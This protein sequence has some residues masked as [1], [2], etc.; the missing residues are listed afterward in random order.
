M[1]TI[2][3]LIAHGSRLAEAASAHRA[4]CARLQQ[5]LGGIDIEPGFLELTDPDIPAAI[6]SAVADGAERVVVLPYFLHPGNHTLRDIPAAVEAARNRHPQI[7]I[8]QAAMFG[9][10]PAIIGALAEQVRTSLGSD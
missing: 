8:D 3:V 7:T 4:V 10:D 1:H 5:E 2:V 9:A 6:D